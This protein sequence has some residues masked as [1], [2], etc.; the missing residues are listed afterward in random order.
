VPVVAGPAAE[1]SGHSPKK[2]AA[3]STLSRRRTASRTRS[4]AVRDREPERAAACM[5]AHLE[6]T[7]EMVARALSEV[8]RAD[9][10][11]HARV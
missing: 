3:S 8:G 10:A 6:G 1:S 2:S 9:L 11:L 4:A 5:R 7:R